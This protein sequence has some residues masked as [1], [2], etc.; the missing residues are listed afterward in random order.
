VNL[1]IREIVI[2]LCVSFAFGVIVVHYMDY[3][4][5]KYLLVL[6]VIAYFIAQVARIIKQLSRSKVNLIEK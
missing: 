3:G 6:T 1:V 4:D 2:F 5:I